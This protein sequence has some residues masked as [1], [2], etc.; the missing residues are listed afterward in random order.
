VSVRLSWD[1]SRARVTARRVLTALLA[2]PALA[3]AD[4]FPDTVFVDGFEPCVGV[5]CFQLRCAGDQT[6]S[7]S[8]K[9]TMPNGT[10]PLPNVQVYVPSTAVD[11]LSNGPDYDRCGVA[12]SG[13]PITATLTDENG[14]FTL[15]NMPATTNV[16]LVI[17]AGKWR[18]Q[19]T[20]ASVA[21]CTDT[22]LAAV[23][24]RLPR[25]HN[26]GHLPQLAIVTGNAD[27]IE[28][29]VRKSGIDDAEFS[30]SSGSGRVHLFV[31]NGTNK[32]DP[33]L[34]GATFADATS[35]WGSSTSLSAYDQVMFGCEGSQNPSTKPQN[36]IDALKTYADSGGR[37]YLAH[38]QNI[39]IAGDFNNPSLT[40]SW[41][42]IATWSTS[43]YAY[44]SFTGQID[45]TFVEGANFAAWLFSVNASPSYGTLPI[46]QARQ[47][48]L[49]I[50]SS[51]A[52]RWIYLTTT[53]SGNPSVQYF[54]FTTPVD[55]AATA[56]V[57]RV[58]FTDMHGAA[59]TSPANGSFPSSGCVSSAINAQEKALLYATFD[60]QR[61][62][63]STKE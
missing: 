48:A 41:P 5:Q 45:D 7:V 12:P 13:H 6:T 18:R 63:G 20:I 14:N 37:V 31:G 52:H 9:V 55:A 15:G 19:I 22:P 27:S 43:G 33:A 21:Q 4:A 29:V 46:T 47:T 39:W 60:L 49:S 58:L 32:L 36:A 25:N 28:C 56:Q 35:L 42:S 57:G 40:G 62:V 50:D 53:T 24:T 34:G 8:G 26:E 17:L 16:P 3:H 59:D 23:D 51:L 38:W 1:P 44:T 54:S 2:A 11:A 61:C 30:T 10:L